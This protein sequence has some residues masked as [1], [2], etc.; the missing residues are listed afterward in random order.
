MTP[1][2]LLGLGTAVPDHE[3][4]QDR[5]KCLVRA[6]F[7][8]SFDGLD[9]F[10][11]VFDRSGVHSR[12]FS[13]PP[14]WFDD[15]HDFGERNDRYR[16]EAFD[17]SVRAADRAIAAAAIEPASIGAVFFVSSTG[18]ATP[19]LDARLVQH[20]GLALHGTRRTAVFG[21]GC[22]GGVGGLGQALE[23]T[24][25][26]PE[27]CALLIA[28]ELCSLAF[29]RDAATK[30]DLVA[31]SLFADGSAA[32]VL[33]RRDGSDAP[34]LVGAG[35]TLW[36]DTADVMGWDV[37]ARGL[38]VV[39]SRSVP[40]LVRREFR[41]SAEAA[42]RRHGTSVDDIAHHIFHPGSAGVLAALADSLGLEPDQLRWSARVLYDHGNMSAPTA[43][44]VLERF[45]AE[46]GGRPGEMGLISAMGP[47]FAA[48]HVVFRC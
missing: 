2:R 32:A 47:G 22:A 23:W 8:D 3:V 6:M 39:L 12:S 31:A 19:S 7:A 44:F 17:L 29:R 42:C 26:Q 43:L 34:T 36:P 48:E 11:G 38:G 41:A 24:A 37:D 1:V 14:S 4:D 35:S 20:L 45:L 40:S 9:R 28:T 33:G 21:H 15:D 46:D 30:T 25:A 10:V 5:A 27:R 13:V 18:V 16:V